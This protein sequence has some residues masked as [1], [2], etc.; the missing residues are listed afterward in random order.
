MSFPAMMA[1]IDPGAVVGPLVTRLGRLTAAPTATIVTLAD[2][3][4]SQPAV[5]AA[6][7]L[8]SP[9]QV[10]DRSTLFRTLRL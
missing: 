6:R 8:S 4:A 2:F 10:H 9:G 7:P 1:E 3:T 5:A